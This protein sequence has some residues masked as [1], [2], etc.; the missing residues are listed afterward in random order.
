MFTEPFASAVKQRTDATLKEWRPVAKEVAGATSR[1]CD[2]V[3]PSLLDFASGENYQGP[4]EWPK[5]PKNLT[6]RHGYCYAV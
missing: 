3:S 4:A 2:P 1:L 5:T 6:K